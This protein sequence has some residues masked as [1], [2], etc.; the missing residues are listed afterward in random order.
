MIR[1]NTLWSPE[2]ASMSGI[3]KNYIYKFFAHG[4]VWAQILIIY[5]VLAPAIYGVLLKNCII[6]LLNF[7]IIFCFFCIALSI[8]YDAK[9]VFGKVDS[10]V[11]YIA[12]IY[13]M[14]IAGILPIMLILRRIRWI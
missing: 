11:D 2:T 9:R 4:F 1:I 3:I 7:S 8:P 6:R 10:I 12:M 14:L 13:H 5:G